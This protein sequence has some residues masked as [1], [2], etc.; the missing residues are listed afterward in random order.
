MPNAV[1]ARTTFFAAL[2]LFLGTFVVVSPAAQFQNGKSFPVGKYPVQAAAG[3]FNND[4]KMDL[5]VANTGQNYV[6]ILLGNGVGGFQLPS[7]VKVNGYPY[8]V[9]VGDLNGDGK[10]DLAVGLNLNIAILLG[11]GDGTFQAP[12]IINNYGT[13]SLTLV[14]FN[15]DGILDLLYL[16]GYV[17]VQLGNGD[18]SFQHKASFQVNGAYKGFAIADFNQDGNLDIAV[19]LSEFVTNQIAVLLGNGSGSFGTAGTYTVDNYPTSLVAAD[20]NGDGKLDLAV[21]NNAGGS[22]AGSV[23]VLMGKGDGSF[24]QAHIFTNLTGQNA[25]TIVA[26]DFDRDGKMDVAVAS[27]YSN[28]VTELLGSGTGTFNPPI[29]WSVGNGAQY[30]LVSDFNGDSIPDLVSVNYLSDDIT[31]LLGGPAGTF[32]GAR[33]TSVGTFPLFG[34]V[35]DFNGDGKPD[36]V[37]SNVGSITVMLAKG[38]GAFAA[39]VTYPV[40]GPTNPFVVVADLNGDSHLDIIAVNQNLYASDTVSILLGKGDGTFQP[41]VDYAVGVSS[42]SAAVADFNGDGILDLAVANRGYLQY[43][44][45]SILI[46]VGDGTFQPAASVS[47]ASFYPDSVIAGDFNGDGKVDLADVAGSDVAV[48][49]GN[50]DGTF[51]SGIVT[52]GNSSNAIFGAAADLNGDGNLDLVTANYLANNVSVL[53]GKGDGTFQPAKFY[54]PGPDPYGVA[55]A[56]F[57]QDGILDVAVANDGGFGATGSFSLLRGKGDGTF[58]ISPGGPVGCN[59]ISIA[60]GDFNADG[61]PDLAIF[62]VQ[63]N[64]ATILMN[65]GQ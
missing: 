3:D 8:G 32:A 65:T 43:G 17:E 12:M 60:L 7:K 31:L 16:D 1:A 44:D 9:A 33:D 10:P 15:H 38:G 51:R 22:T 54:S 24:G 29:N 18:G 36:L 2:L 6:T 11:N 57:N 27:S 25:S 47:V 48:S 40:T 41:A 45:I 52:T 4:G 34:A 50:G 26:S 64:E 35:G 39:P 58:T 13:G 56:D 61:R 37:A 20:L 59:P 42:I 53:L 14:D 19:T 63:G 49:L 55:I 21:S 46:G 30:L 28:N 23:S 5:V 62:S